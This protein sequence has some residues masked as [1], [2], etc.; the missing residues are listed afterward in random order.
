MLV[1]G[2]APSNVHPIPLVKRVHWCS[3]G[4][5]KIHMGSRNRDLNN[6]S[7][8]WDT[9]E[10]PTGREGKMRTRSLKWVAALPKRHR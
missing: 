7:A 3:V 6:F 4:L 10:S 9:I 5:G 1:K 2:Q 8:R